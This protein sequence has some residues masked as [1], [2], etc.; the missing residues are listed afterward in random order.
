MNLTPQMVGGL[1]PAAVDNLA[2]ALP[3]VLLLGKQGASAY[4][5]IP[6]VCVRVVC[7]DVGGS[8]DCHGLS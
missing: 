7:S 5:I 8:A 1:G 4:Y 6:H 2:N 3:V